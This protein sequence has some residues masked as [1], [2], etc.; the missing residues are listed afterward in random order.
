MDRALTIVLV[1]LLHLTLLSV[2]TNS[3][4]QAGIFGSTTAR[5]SYDRVSVR[6]KPSS[7][8]G[9]EMIVEGWNLAAGVIGETGDILKDGISGIL[10][11]MG[12][13]CEPGL[14][15]NTT[16]PSPEFYDLPR[17]ALIRRGGP[18]ND[19][20]CTFR[21]KILNAQANNSIGALIYNNPGTT[22]LDGAT[23][24]LDA[25]D[26]LEIPGM[27]ISYDD[28]IM[29]RTFLQ[30]TQDIGTVD[31]FNRVRVSMALSKRRP[32]VWEFV[33]IV[34]VILLAI[35]IIVSV[36]LHCR[37]YAL[38]QRIRMDAL[39]RGADVLPNGNIRMRKVTIDKAILDE[40]PVRVY[41][42]SPA[43][44]ALTTEPTT[45][46][47][48]GS[49]TGGQSIASSSQ[50]VTGRPA[51]LTRTSSAKGS[52]SSK[53]V[54][55]LKAMTAATFLNSST[56]AVS[57]QPASSSPVLDEIT[58][59]TCAVCLDE[60]AEGEEIRTLPCHHE[61]H[62]EC[63]DPWLTRKSSTCPLCKYDCLPQTTEEAQGRGEDANIIMPSD[64]LIEFIMGPDW[65]AARILRG[66]N[67]NNFVDRAVIQVS[68]SCSI[69]PSTS[70]DYGINIRT[71]LVTNTSVHIN[72]GISTSFGFIVKH[73]IPKA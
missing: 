8:G 5:L 6:S 12:Y 14:N 30:Q 15:D 9:V 50:A 28:G 57:A 33:L 39:A 51:T 17:I 1:V 54:R 64:R 62:C 29:L 34:V 67:G 38:R 23:A 48:N 70:S 58:S 4:V 41:Q 71:S 16:L 31:F 18:T 25:T 49:G 2:S 43:A 46:Q 42:Q 59:D 53:S 47:D 11:D 55:S 26:P 45:H 44:Q 24:K 37:L 35:L 52:I 13:A 3:F 63:I 7:I 72:I 36:V 22:A 66:H 20:A 27:L 65:V 60:F 69:R 56:N 40:L 10:F 21:T 61:F 73:S 68:N 19:D 32:V